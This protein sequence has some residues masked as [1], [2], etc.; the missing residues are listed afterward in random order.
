METC[1]PEPDLKSDAKICHFTC[2]PTSEETMDYLLMTL[3]DYKIVCYAA[4]LGYMSFSEPITKTRQNK[5]GFGL[6]PQ[7][8]IPGAEGRIP[9]F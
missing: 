4:L 2:R 7:Q 1:G 8:L 9:D 3:Q 6:S 5:T